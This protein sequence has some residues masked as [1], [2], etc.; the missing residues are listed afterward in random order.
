MSP[1][2]NPV[3]AFAGLVRPFWLP[4]TYPLQAS[5]A[6]LTLASYLNMAGFIVRNLFPWVTEV[7]HISLG[8][9][10]EGRTPS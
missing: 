9:Q 7:L 8:R 6:W 3:R 4:V 2:T 10:T 1:N 5:R